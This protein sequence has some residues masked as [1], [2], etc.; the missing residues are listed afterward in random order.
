MGKAR[1]TGSTIVFDM[2]GQSSLYSLTFSELL[3]TDIKATTIVLTIVGSLL[4]LASLVF[5][6]SLLYDWINHLMRP[7]TTISQEK[8]GS[9][10]QL[11]IEDAPFSTRTL[12]FQF[13][14]LSFLS[15]WM[16]AILIPSTI[17]SRTRSAHLTIRGPDAPNFILTISPSYWY[18]GFCEYASKPTDT[19]ILTL[20]F[21]L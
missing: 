6:L 5:S 20:T 18:Y 19:K 1:N 11:A 21:D 8:M 14:V 7:K 3:P 4:T 10:D 16:L 13:I 9:S 12:R 17:F 15:V 2:N